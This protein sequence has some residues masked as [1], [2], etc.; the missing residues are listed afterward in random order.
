MPQHSSKHFIMEVF[1]R[2]FS[3]GLRPSP[4][5]KTLQHRWR[6][7]LAEIPNP[8]AKITAQ[9]LGHSLHFHASRPS[10]Q[11]PN[12]L[13]EPDHRFRRDPPFR[14]PIRRETKAQKL[15]LPWPPHRTLLLVHLELE[16][17]R[18]ESRNARHHSLSCPP[19]TNVHITVVRIPREPET[20][21]LQLPVE[22]VEHDIT[23]QRRQRTALRR[24]LIDR[25]HQ[26]AFHHPG[27]QKRPD[28]L[29]HPPIADPGFDSGHQFV[30]RNPVEKFLEV[31]VHASTHQR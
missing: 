7:A 29:Q 12:L 25:T 10:R 3:G 22:L 23:E 27:S 6:L 13:F 14:L 11:F 17:R 1:Y 15:P 16:L 19:A 5:L 8:A 26:P 28:Q 21:P 18:D 4:L 24:P 2:T 20:S 9:L 30:M 31:Q